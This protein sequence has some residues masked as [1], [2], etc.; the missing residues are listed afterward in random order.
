M[1]LQKIL[2]RTLNANTLFIMNYICNFEITILSLSLQIK[3]IEKKKKKQT[4]GP[5]AGH[6]PV[7]HHL[8]SLFHN[9]NN[10]WTPKRRGQWKWLPHV[11]K[12][13]CMWS[14]PA[15]M[16]SESL[17]RRVLSIFWFT[18]ERSRQTTKDPGIVEEIAGYIIAGMLSKAPFIVLSSYVFRLKN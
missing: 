8:I 9:N 4:P 3:K 2:N 7:G 12:R 18:T 17:P 6:P 5:T 13:C 10:I 15:K 1:K 14:G 16:Q 11:L